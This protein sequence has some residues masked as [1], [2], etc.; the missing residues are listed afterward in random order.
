MKKRDAKPN[1]IFILSDQQRWDTLSC[2]RKP[3]YPGLTPN[4]DRMAKEGI[5]FENAFT[6]QPVC[7]PARSCIQTGKWVTQTGCFTNG[8]ALPTDQK[9]I[10]HYLSESGYSV[11]YIGKWHLASNRR[12]GINFRDKPVP[13][14]R[15]GG[16]TD[17][18]LAS[19]VLEFTSH[20][21]DGHMY[22]GDMERVEFPED[23]YRA[24]C[25]TDFCL[26]AIEEIGTQKPFFLFLSFIEPHQQND[27]KQ[28]EGP[29]G[30]RERFKDFNTP[31]DL[32]GREGD[33][34][35]ELPD[36]L[37][38]VNSLDKNLGRI[39]TRLQEL[40]QSEKTLLIY[41]SDHGCHFR[42]RNSEYKRSCHESAIR[43][44]MVIYGPGFRGGRIIEDLVS[45]VD[46]PSTVLESAGLEAP[47]YMVGRSL[48]DIVVNRPVNWRSEVFTQISET[49]VGRAL[50]TERWKYSIRAPDKDGGLDMASKIY[51]EDFLYDLQND[52][53]ENNNLVDDPEYGHIR[54]SL[55]SVLA[56]RMVQAG[57]QEPI[58]QEK[59][60]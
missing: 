23:R 18:W 47:D 28:F 49:H 35:T 10:A 29:A 16:Y 56:R 48:Q 5:R 53:N 50:R 15:R 37:G 44:P 43:I 6:P 4:L 32:E 52:P 38:A 58:I 14:E 8:I 19:D 30:S 9:T 12:K 57:E 7:G 55:A 40:G 3:I 60:R 13:P 51:R 22:N 31:G 17:Y 11:G 45:L 54:S 24:D 2:Y 25:L 21:Y 34:E 46:L 33:W 39:R 27:H 26:E 41:T 36:Y 42:T 59:K 20:S 1:I